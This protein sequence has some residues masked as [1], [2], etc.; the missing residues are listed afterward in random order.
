MYDCFLMKIELLSNKDF[1]RNE[2]SH[3]DEWRTENNRTFSIRR[4]FRRM[5]ASEA[6]E[7][8]ISFGSLL[9]GFFLKLLN[10]TIFVRTVEQ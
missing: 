2:F 7:C 1:W 10:L 8:V 3:R 6:R 4:K 9:D 5:R